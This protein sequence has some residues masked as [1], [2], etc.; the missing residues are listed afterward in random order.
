[1]AKKW[2]ADPFSLKDKLI[3]RKIYFYKKCINL[4]RFAH[5][6]VTGKSASY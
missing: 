6:V 3:D 1:M 5:F 2:I 4:I